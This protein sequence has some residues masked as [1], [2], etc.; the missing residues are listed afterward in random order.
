ME[1]VV[2][3]Y[4]VVRVPVKVKSTSYDRAVRKVTDSIEAGTTNLRRLVAETG[5]YADDFANHVI[6]DRLGKDGTVE[7]SRTLD[8]TPL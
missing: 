5:E 4:A 6:V 7:E 2:H 8:I 3:V 1:Y